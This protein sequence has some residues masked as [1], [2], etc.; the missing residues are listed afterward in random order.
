MAKDPACLFYWG[1]WSG[2]TITFTR[3]LKGCYMDLLNAQFNNGPLSLD[4]VKTVLGSDF[5]S[6][7]PTLQKKFKIGETGLFFN[8]RLQ[9]EKDKRV[10]YSRS[11]KENAK[12]MVEHM[13]KHMENEPEIR[14]ENQKG[15]EFENYQKWTDQILDDND[16]YFQ[17][18]FNNE[19]LTM[20]AETFVH[21][22]RDHLDLLARYPNMKP[23]DQQRFRG[24]CMKHI[25][26]NYKKR[27]SGNGNRKEQYAGDL[28]T[29]HAKRWGSGAAKK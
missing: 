4:E 1:D 28:H 18:M 29:A 13:P 21:L 19:G 25:R 22:V 26:E 2:G 5:G 8:E 23:P 16:Q 10:N 15:A 11:R 9:H 14:I 6:S 27:I 20:T 7:W 12:H 24:S 17:V 3:H